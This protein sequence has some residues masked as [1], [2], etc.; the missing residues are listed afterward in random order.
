[1]NGI[2]VVIFGPNIQ[3]S[4][5]IG[6][7]FSY[8]KQASTQTN[9]VA[10]IDTRG[11]A[12]NPLTSLGALLRAMIQA[13]K[14]KF[15]RRIDLAHVNFGANGS[16]FRKTVLVI[17]LKI[18]LHVP[19]IMHL[20]A[21]SFDTW[22]DSEPKVVKKIVIAALNL[23]DRVLVLG[24]IWR[25]M[26]ETRGVRAGKIQTF[27]MGVPDLGKSSQISRSEVDNI[28]IVFA[29]EMGTRKG[30]PQ[31]I[32]AMGSPE[33]E[34]LTLTVAGKGDIAKWT[35][36]ATR[37]NAASKIHF[38]GHVSSNVIHDL[39]SKS[40]ILILPSQA[41]GMPV[42]IMEGLSSGVLVITSSAGAVTE[43]LTDEED[44]LILRSVSPA[45]ILRSL[46]MAREL[47]TR[48]TLSSAGR[49]TWSRRFDAEK[50]SAQLLSIWDDVSK[51]ENKRR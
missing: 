48:Q 34:G 29:G 49:L 46:K 27:I 25:N 20:H 28:R 12:E 7:L 33:A 41:E 21:S 8:F 2:Y 17:W 9:R 23:S 31:L 1:M 14:L 6:T 35:N 40:D 43:Y 10:F 13:A 3:N 32:V 11:L 5:G 4:G 18:F 16:A 38:A 15:N 22:F 36:Y 47:E 19:T 24:E 44:C 42:S 30:L 50:T 39:L 37:E 45:D 26:L 51:V